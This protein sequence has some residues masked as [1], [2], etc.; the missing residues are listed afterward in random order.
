[1]R[2]VAESLTLPDGHTYNR[3]ELT[4]AFLNIFEHCDGFCLDNSEER[5]ALADICAVEF[6]A[7]EGFGPDIVDEI[8]ATRALKED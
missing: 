4:A 7:K 1:M 2:E 5:E 8:L 3:K 6:L